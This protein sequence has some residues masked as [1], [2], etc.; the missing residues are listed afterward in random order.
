MPPN[1]A[2]RSS[3]PN[4]AERTVHHG[5]ALSRYGLS[6]DAWYGVP[7]YAAPDF[8]AVWAPYSRQHAPAIRARP[9]SVLPA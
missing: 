6:H 4:D 3:S 1:M 5:A 9:I 7:T 8:T 2:N